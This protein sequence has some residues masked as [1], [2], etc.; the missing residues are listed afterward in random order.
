ML[1]QRSKILGAAWCDYLPH[2][3]LRKIRV[4]HQNIDYVLNDSESGT[5]PTVEYR[6][7]SVAITSQN[8]NDWVECRVITSQAGKYIKIQSMTNNR[9][10]RIS[11]AHRVQKTF[12]ENAE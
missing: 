8:S 10:S 2:L 9:V 5:E 12:I 3:E 6:P 7:I 4:L 1:A 11:V